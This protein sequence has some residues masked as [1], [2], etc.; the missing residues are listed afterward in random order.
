M[1][2]ELK[3]GG[4]SINDSFAH[5]SVNTVAFGGVGTSGT[6]AYRGKASFDSFTHFRIVAKTPSWMESL[7]RPRYMP[8]RMSE[9]R[10]L[11]L[12]TTKSPNFDRNGKEIRGLAYWAS[13]VLTLGGGCFRGVVARWLALAAT[14]YIG[15]Y[16]FVVPERLAP[17]VAALRR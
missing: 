3:S 5:A 17:L 11:A 16:G 12:L 8:Y 2:K 7:L 4:A 1:L 13:F 6:G 14:M 10:R 9:L 15:M